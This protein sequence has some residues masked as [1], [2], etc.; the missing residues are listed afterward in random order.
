[1]LFCMATDMIKEADD[2]YLKTIFSF[3]STGFLQSKRMVHY[4]GEVTNLHYS[5]TSSNTRLLDL[6][7]SQ[8]WVHQ[9]KSLLLNSPVSRCDRILWLFSANLGHHY[10]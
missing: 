7:D 3:V 5:C 1:M 6:A 10:H 8:L 9:T 2:T 4:V